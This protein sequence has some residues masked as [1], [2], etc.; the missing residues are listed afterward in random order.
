MAQ[1][2]H[3]FIDTQQQD[4]TIPLNPTPNFNTLI[5]QDKK[6][7][8]KSIQDLKAS[9]LQVIVYSDGSRIQGKN[10]AASEWCDNNKHS[11]T[12]QPGK[13]SDY[14]IFEAEFSGLIL[15]LR[16]AKHSFSLTTRRITLILN[17]QGV[18]KDMAN[19]KT[20]SRAL[21]KKLEAIKIINKI[22]EIASHVKIVLQ[23]CPG[24]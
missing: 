4:S 2:L 5:I 19:K 24:H 11:S 12:I 23:W 16:L 18:V 14:G 13:E 20:S 7:A 3:Q 6:K 1:Q 9:N 10:T 21:N 8:I 17:N 22:E 15:A